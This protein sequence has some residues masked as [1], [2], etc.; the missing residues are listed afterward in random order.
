MI[1]ILFAKLINLFWILGPAALILGFLIFIHDLGHFLAARL[2]GIRVEVFS[3]G[4]GKR[5][6]GFRRGDTDYRLSAIPFGGYVRM[7]GEELPGQGD[8]DTEQEKTTD[9]ETSIKPFED[10][11]GDT[12]QDKSVP[13]RIFVAVAGAFMNAVVAVLLTVALAYFGI[14]IESYLMEPP[15]VAYVQSDSPAEKAGI[16]PEDQIVEINGKTVETWEE[17]EIE[18]LLNAFDSYL[19]TVLRDKE[20]L[21]KIIPAD[22]D[23]KFPFA[24]LDHSSKVFIGGLSKDSPAEKAGLK[25]ND[26]II[27]IDDF[28]LSGIQQMV[29]VVNSS[30][31]EPITLTIRRDDLIETMTMKPE[32]NKDLDRYMIGIAFGSDPDKVLKTYP[33]DQ[34]FKKGVELNLQMGTAMFGLVAKLFIGRESVD[35]LGGPIMI[36]DMAGKAARAGIRELI[37]LTALISLNL[38]I[39]NLLPIPILDGG[40]VLFLLFEA[41]FRKPISEKIQLVIQNVF[42]FLLIAFALYITYNDILRLA[43][44]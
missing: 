36:V 2:V 42:F 20:E 41:I 9:S 23:R 7:A 30:L 17:T 10:K 34:A 35:Q 39:L 29:D 18:L 3:I 44:R 14:Y 21:T 28:P 40:M 6:F 37:W 26:Q 13:Q 12:L 25:E 38:A 32:Y 33:L 19:I 11:K 15:V 8:S 5:L 1:E 16:L 4:F 27:A 24:G 43:F 22:Q 31:G